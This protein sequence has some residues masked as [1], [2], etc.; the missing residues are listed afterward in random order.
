MS[1]LGKPESVKAIMTPAPT[2]V[3]EQCAIWLQYPNGVIAQLFSTFASNLATEADICGTEGRL[4][5]THRFYSP[6]AVIEF[7]PGHPDT[8]QII[9]VDRGE[10]HGYQYEAQH[11]CDC[12][13]QG[14]TESPVMTLDDSI[15]LMQVLDAVRKEAGIVY[16]ED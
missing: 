16:P 6:D 4:R 12:L 3:D 7:Y 5:L 10:G 14:L 8:R 1:V 13:R 9:P 2:G 15:E 11:V